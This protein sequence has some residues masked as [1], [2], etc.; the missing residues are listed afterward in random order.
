MAD[1]FVSLFIETK[2]KDF[3][4]CSAS[5][6]NKIMDVLQNNVQ[7]EQTQGTDH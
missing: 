3:A 5:S 2:V 4:S 1:Q 6:K 7:R